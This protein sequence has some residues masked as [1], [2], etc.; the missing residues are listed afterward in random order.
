[1][2]NKFVIRDKKDYQDNERYYYLKNN[3]IN[4][5]IEKYLDYRVKNRICFG[6]NPDQFR[7]LDPNEAFFISYRNKGYSLIQ[8]GEKYKCDAL[9]RHIKTL[10][11]QGG[12]EVPSTL[13]GRRTFAVSLHRQGCDIAHLMHMLGDRTVETTKKL[14]EQDTVDIG[15][16]A[17]NAF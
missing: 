2:N 6:D 5:L 9:N 15:A 10:L 11:K 14:I 4:A 8:N 1:M 3:R 7:G 12:V 17:A 16:I 13:S